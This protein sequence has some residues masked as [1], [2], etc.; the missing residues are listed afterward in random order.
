MPGN[1]LQHPIFFCDLQCSLNSEEEFL[2][3]FHKKY[4]A[5]RNNL[6]RKFQREGEGIIY[7]LFHLKP[8]NNLTK[9]ESLRSTHVNPSQT[10]FCVVCVQELLVCK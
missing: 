4:G 6:V 7:F 8:E 3:Y 10:I 1:T 9:T 5:K 2:F